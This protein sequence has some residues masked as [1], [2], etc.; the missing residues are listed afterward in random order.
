MGR[1]ARCGD[2]RRAS[3]VVCV[4]LASWSGKLSVKGHPHE[5]IL[6]SYALV[7]SLVGAF[8]KFGENDECAILSVAVAILRQSDGN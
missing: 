7:C 4:K 6:Q 5:G 3:A 2:C 1:T 8:L